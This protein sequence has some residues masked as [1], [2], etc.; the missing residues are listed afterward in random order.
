MR[1]PGEIADMLTGRA[2]KDLAKIDAALISLDGS[3]DKSRLG[4]NAIVGTSM[5]RARA[6]AIIDGQELWRWLS[7]PGAAPRLPVPHFNV[8]NGG[9]HAANLLDFQEFMIAPV[10]ARSLPE[11]VRAGAEVYAALRALLAEKGHRTGWPELIEE[12]HGGTEPD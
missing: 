3:Q 11:A 8:I 10:E 4:A 1:V 7:T 2:W 6:Q 9:A 5:A 12:V